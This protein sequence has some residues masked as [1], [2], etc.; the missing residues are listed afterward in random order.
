VALFGPGGWDEPGHSP[1]PRR[2]ERGDR[3][4]HRN[5]RRVCTLILITGSTGNVGRKLVHL[6]AEQG[7]AVRALVRD[8]ARARFPDGVDVAVGDLDDPATVTAAAKGV[9][10]IFH[11]QASPFPAQT[12]TVIAA[13]HGAGV[14]RVV[15]MTSIGAVVEPLA[16][17]G[18]FFRAREDLLRAS[19]LAVTYLRPNTL[20]TN[21]LWWRDSIRETGAV[22]DPCGDG[23]MPCVDSDDIAAVAA[24]TLTEPG[25]EGHGYILTGPE[26]MTTREQLDVLG[27]VLGKHIALVD[28]TPHEFAAAGV[29]NGTTPAE[30]EPVIEN[31]YTLFR[32]GRAGVLS[33][34]VRNVTG[35][36]PGT[37]RAWCE[38]N[39]AAFR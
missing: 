11:M 3:N 29:A 18:A 17:M 31:L 28:T 23:R 10:A 6:L 15:A 7:H 14:D 35:R 27:D 33:D 21:A 19:G 8:P 38:R 2:C 36:A 34:D 39:A 37:F 26:A 5:A 24:T 32:A 20:M 25:H 1:R 13:A 30:M 22:I 12:E 16:T 4:V 9:E